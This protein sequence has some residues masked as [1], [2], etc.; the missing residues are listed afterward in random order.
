[1]KTNGLQQCIYGRC[2]VSHPV[3]DDE[4]ESSFLAF[5]DGIPD[6]AN[7][8]VKISLFHALPVNGSYGQTEY[9]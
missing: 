4:D 1:M 5:R 2:N 9:A 3:M 6:A 8:P 7:E